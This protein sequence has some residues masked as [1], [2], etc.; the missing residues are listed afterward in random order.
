M[1]KLGDTATAVG[2]QSLIGRLKTCCW[3]EPHPPKPKFQSLIGRLKTRL[4]LI[5]ISL[6]KIVSIPHR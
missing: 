2:F 5:Y 4:I 6:K 3:D 1:G